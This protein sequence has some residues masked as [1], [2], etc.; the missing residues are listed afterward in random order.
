MHPNRRRAILPLTA[1]TCLV[2]LLLQSACLGTGR[3]DTLR[4]DLLHK[5]D[6]WA[7]CDPSGGDDQC[8]VV[9]GDEADC[10]GV[11]R[12]AFAVNRANR[13]IAEDAVITNAS[14]WPVCSAVCSSP[15]CGDSP[16]PKCD[17]TLKRCVVDVDLDGGQV[18]PIEEPD[19][20]PPV[21][22]EKDAATKDA[23]GG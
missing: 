16:I 15:T 2:G 22:P 9:S 12:C 21:Q 8:V 11:L 5:R 1:L 4:N 6:L 14:D 17:A 18:G 23:L 20:S 13:G 3:C 7:A 10:T 19:A